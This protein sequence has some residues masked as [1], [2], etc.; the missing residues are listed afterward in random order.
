MLLAKLI[1]CLQFDNLRRV[2][3][4]AEATQGELVDHI[5]SEFAFHEALAR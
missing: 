1:C 5:A 3:K 4:L 2:Y